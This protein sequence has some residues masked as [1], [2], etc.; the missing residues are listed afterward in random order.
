MSGNGAQGPSFDLDSRQ[1]FLELVEE[2]QNAQKVSLN[3]LT[4]NYVADLMR[5]Y[6]VSDHLFVTSESG[7]KTQPTLA[8]QYL[9]AQN[10]DARER[11]ELLKRT[12]DQA[13]YVSGFF[14]QSLTR[15]VV[16]VDYYVN[17]GSSAYTQLSYCIREAT[18][19]DLYSEISQR[20]VTLVDLL[21]Y[22]SRKT[23]PVNGPAQILEL[24]SKYSALGSEDAKRQ[25]VEAGVFN[26]DSQGRLSRAQ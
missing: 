5:Y 24:F 22:I 6:L 14:G 10:S 16:D 17:M 4:Q 26:V 3:L 23:M 20:F 25:L 8:E 11:I 9:K 7:K 18:F 2:A 1:Y 21:S 15:K 19:T 12:G 13:L